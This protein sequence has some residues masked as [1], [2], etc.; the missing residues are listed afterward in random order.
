M[1]KALT[2][3]IYLFVVLLNAIKRRLNFL[4]I[5][6]TG[7]EENSL[8]N[9]CPGGADHLLSALR[10]QGSIFAMFTADHAS[11]PDDHVDREPEGHK[12]NTV[13]M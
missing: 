9:N 5:I 7:R 1:R 10:C 8:W 11:E 12:S 13:P 6:L 3:I 2:N 4:A